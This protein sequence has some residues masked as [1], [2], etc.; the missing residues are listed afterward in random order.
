M[1]VSSKK[2]STSGTTTSTNTATS[3]PNVPDWLLQPARTAAGGL[4]HLLATDPSTFAP[5]ESA[6]QKQATASAGA[7]TTSPLLGQAAAGAQGINTTFDPGAVQGQSLLDGLQN[8]YNPFKDQILNPVLGDY[9]VNSGRT[10]AA[11]SARMAATGAFR[12]SRSGIAT[13]A[14]EGELARGRSATE[15]GLLKDMFNTATTLSG[16]DADRRQS[17]MTG[18]VDRSLS[19]QTSGASDALAKY[20]LLGGLGMDAGAEA[21]ANA[22]AQA[23]QGAIQ[24]GIDN[25]ITQAPL[26]T[27]GTLEGLLAG[28]DPAAYSGTTV[29]S[30]GSGTSTGTTTLDPSLGAILGDFLMASASGAGK[31]VAAGG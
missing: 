15:G 13:A 18:N 22:G 29:N 11:Q 4:S 16:Q 31:A 9:D 1:G 27:Q 2:S 12:G 23:G 26:T 30:S 24:T 8:Y 14:T 6:L 17:A 28:L 10:R 5:T 20:G 21:R 19:A 3:T 25:A 7:L